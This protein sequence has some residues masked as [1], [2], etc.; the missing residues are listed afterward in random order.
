M[1]LA[2]AVK[3]QT[4]WAWPPHQGAVSGAFDAEGPVHL[5]SLS[6]G[7]AAGRAGAG[8]LGGTE[9]GV[10]PCTQLRA[11][12]LGDP[13]QGRRGVRRPGIGEVPRQEA[14]LCEAC[15]SSFILAAEFLTPELPLVPH[16]VCCAD[17][18]PVAE[19]PAPVPMCV[20]SPQWEGAWDSRVT[21]RIR[22]RRHVCSYRHGITCS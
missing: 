22:Q 10:G 14:Q 4:F 12:G 20:P 6:P 2:A 1:T 17:L 3:R 7:L 16:P 19:G 5:G 8:N 18:E 11:V 21:R 13:V 15:S 9:S